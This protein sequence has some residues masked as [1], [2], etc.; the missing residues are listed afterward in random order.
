MMG[1]GIGAVARVIVAVA[2]VQE[3]P[4]VFAPGL[5]DGEARLAL[6]TTMGCRLLP[7]EAEAPTMDFVLPPRSLGETAGEGGFVGALQETAGEIGH[8]LMG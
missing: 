5:I 2:I 1:P 6:P 3:A 8:T 7:P 4:H